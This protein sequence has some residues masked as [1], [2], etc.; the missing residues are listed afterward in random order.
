MSNANKGLAI[1]SQECARCRRR[2][3]LVGNGVFRLH[4]YYRPSVRRPSGELGGYCDASGLTPDQARG[5]VAGDI[6]GHGHVPGQ[7][8][9]PFGGDGGV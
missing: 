7:R 4:K 3:S 2:I 9:L 6:V 8:A 1:A 5:I